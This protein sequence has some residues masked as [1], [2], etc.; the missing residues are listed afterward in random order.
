MQYADEIFYY[1][2]SILTTSAASRQ[3]PR[4]VFLI[5]IKEKKGKK[6]QMTK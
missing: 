6:Y 3:L 2:P 4:T 5:L 1:F